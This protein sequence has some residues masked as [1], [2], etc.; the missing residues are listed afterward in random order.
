MNK[1]DYIF[2]IVNEIFQFTLSVSFLCLSMDLV[3]NRTYVG[4][5]I[6]ALTLS[7]IL[8]NV[9]LALVRLWTLLKT[10]VKSLF[11]KSPQ[12]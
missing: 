1:T 3:R 8:L 10:R 4:W 12:L 5:I 11:R 7:N 6:V 9:I 2:G